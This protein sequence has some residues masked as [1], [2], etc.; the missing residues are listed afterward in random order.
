MR[1]GQQSTSGK[2][3]LALIALAALILLRI[4]PRLVGVPFHR[5]VLSRAYGAFAD[6]LWPDYPHFLDGVRAHTQ[7]GDSIA[8]VVPTFSWEDG[9]SYAFYRASYFLSG[10]EVLP[11]SNSRNEPQILNF[12]AAR[13]VAVWHTEVPREHFT[14]VWSGAGGVLLR[15]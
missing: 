10:R 3:V 8:I 6:R 14:M 4:E 2:R 12:R 5:D 7:P 9:Y 13:Y 15:R 11:L 1:L